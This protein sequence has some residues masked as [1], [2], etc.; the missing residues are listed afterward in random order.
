MSNSQ[1]KNA[2]SPDQLAELGGRIRECVDSF[3][4]RK[5][6]AEAMGISP[7]HMRRLIHG[8][9]GVPNAQVLA[10][11][12]D[13]GGFN[14][15][16]LVSGE[17]SPKA[18]R[19]RVTQLTALAAREGEREANVLLSTFEYATRASDLLQSAQTKVAALGQWRTPKEKDR[20]VGLILATV[21]PTGDIPEDWEARCA[22]A[23]ELLRFGL[24]ENPSSS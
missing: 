8:Q 24:S 23:V 22:A 12:A 21:A 20:A 19:G 15:N 4:T 1:R 7:Q 3:P 9:G 13:A 18:T 5:A 10:R 6:A 11:L 2:L 16:W 17:G 14:L